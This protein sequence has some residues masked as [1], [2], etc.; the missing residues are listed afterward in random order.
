MSNAKG[1]ANEN[2]DSLI[3][4]RGAPALMS[5]KEPAIRMLRDRYSESFALTQGQREGQVHLFLIKLGMWALVW[6]FTPKDFL[7]ER[8]LSSD[9]KKFGMKEVLKLIESAMNGTNS[10]FEQKLDDS[11]SKAL[12][13]MRFKISRLN[14]KS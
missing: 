10:V 13:R 5:P 14:S 12:E 11:V 1:F 6:T 3:S 8:A 4:G 9:E 7:S 2:D